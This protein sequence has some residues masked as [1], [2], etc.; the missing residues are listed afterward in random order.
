MS[1]LQKNEWQEEEK[2]AFGAQLRRDFLALGNVKVL[3]ACAMLAAMGVVLGYLAKMVFG[4]GPLRVTFENLPI[5]FCGIAF[6]P[7]AGGVTA[8]VSDLASCLM[9]GQ[10]MN[11]L[12]TVG[13]LSVGVLSGAV[14]NY[15]LKKRG[16]LS[17]L[18]TELLAHLVGSIFLKTLALHLFWNIA[19]ATLLFR[20][21][22]YLFVAL[23]ESYF[24]WIL[25]KN[26]SV[27]KLLRGVWKR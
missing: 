18:V 15:I 8:V 10:A 17:L 16:F 9:A 13:A 14:S 4:M 11:P 1:K 19:W 2:I 21:P 23:V 25:F 26:K 5:I 24:L 12:I 3:C 22:V 7:L 20:V 6:G 27:Q